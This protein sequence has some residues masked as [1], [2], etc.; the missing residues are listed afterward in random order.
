MLDSICSSFN[1]LPAHSFQTKMCEPYCQKISCNQSP[2]AWKLKP[3]SHFKLHTFSFTKSKIRIL[4]NGLWCERAD[5]TRYDINI[6]GRLCVYSTGEMYEYV[7]LYVAKSCY[8]QLNFW[9]YTTKLVRLCACEFECASVCVCVCVWWFS[10]RKDLT[11]KNTL[12]MC[13]QSAI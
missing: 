13:C 10:A 11:F 5:Q 7:L 3:A 2:F 4:T 1:I 8:K 9:P 12:S 6:T